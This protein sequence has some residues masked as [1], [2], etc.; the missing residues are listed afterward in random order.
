MIDF[1][2]EALD[3]YETAKTRVDWD[4]PNHD[5]RIPIMGGASAGG[6]TTAIAALHAFRKLEPVW[7]GQPLPLHRANRLS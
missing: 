7:P 6:M 5:V 1:I 2:I 4:G 3:A